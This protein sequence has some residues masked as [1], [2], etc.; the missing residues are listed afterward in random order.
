MI[1][2]GPLLWLAKAAVTPTK[3]TI[4]QPM[5]LFPHGVAWDNLSEAWTGVNVGR[6]S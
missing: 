2:L 5:A 6:Y 3:D 1:G 4:T